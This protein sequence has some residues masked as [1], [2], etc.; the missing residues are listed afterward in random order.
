[1]IWAQGSPA[2]LQAVSTI[3]RGVRINLAAAICWENYMPLLRQALYAQNINLYLA[4]TADGRDTWLPL[5]RTVAIEG[6]CFVVSSNMCVRAGGGSGNDTTAA[7]T[8]TATQQQQQQHQHQAV[9]PTH[10][11]DRPSR[12]EKTAAD[13]DRRASCVT[14]EGF[15]IALPS[16]SPTRSKSR[17]KSVFDQD[18]NEIVL[19]CE[20]TVVLEDADDEEEDPR[21]TSPVRFRDTLTN[22]H[23]ASVTATAG[24]AASAPA[25]DEYLTRGG[26]SIVSPFGDVL[27]GP[28]WEDEE[29]IIC[30]DV[31]FEDCIKGRLDLDTA[32][33][34][35]R[36][37]V[38]PPPPPACRGGRGWDSRLL[39]L[40]L[41]NLFR[42]YAGT[43]RS[44]S[45]SRAFR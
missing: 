36:F 24:A 6:R 32:G 41:A 9:S 20:D 35:S 42:T 5:L 7:A 8:T 44:N 10:R 12:H 4:P 28:Q 21:S 3:I 43:I 40:R 30:A 39:L 25:A 17:R 1:M 15:E 18:G 13:R 38:S 45:P 31:D 14:A 37:V 27:A 19:S 29:G 26:S 33:H 11:Q 16:P 22:G 34:Y 2:T 23:A